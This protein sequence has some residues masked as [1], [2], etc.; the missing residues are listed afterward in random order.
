MKFVRSAGEDESVSF[1]LPKQL[2]VIGR[3]SFL[4]CTGLPAD[5][6]VT[7]P[8]SVTYVGSEAFYKTDAI[9]TIIVET[10]DASAYDGGA[11]KGNK[12]GLGQRLIIFNN[13]A[14]KKTFSPSGLSAYKN[15]VTY[16]FTL[17]YGNGS[18]RKDRT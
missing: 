11:F 9:T 6:V 5:T 4:G 15:A 2:Q 16:E 17:H 8:K 14:A 18:E 3:Q 1:I 7:I 12:H 10:D 13:A